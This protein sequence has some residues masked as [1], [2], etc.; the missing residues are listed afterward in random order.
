MYTPKYKNAYPTVYI[1]AA[2][3]NVNTQHKN[4]PEKAKKGAD[5]NKKQQQIEL[6]VLLQWRRLI[7]EKA[8]F[9][10]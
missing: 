10:L 6:K 2:T 4:V 3:T 1:F 7:P 8:C 5:I 9:V